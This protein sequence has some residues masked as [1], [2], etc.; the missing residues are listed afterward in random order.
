MVIHDRSACT[1]PE[2]YHAKKEQ[3]HRLHIITEEIKNAWHKNQVRYTVISKSVCHCK[4][5]ERIVYNH[6]LSDISNVKELLLYIGRPVKIDT[7]VVC[8]K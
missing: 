3:Q 4:R 8:T 6:T 7:S 1:K 2:E 5:P